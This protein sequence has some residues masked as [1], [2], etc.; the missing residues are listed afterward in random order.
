MHSGDPK[1]HSI[2]Q[3]TSEPTVVR[4]EKWLR[5]LGCESRQV[6]YLTERLAPTTREGVSTMYCSQC[7]VANNNTRYTKKQEM[8]SY[9]EKNQLVDSNHEKTQM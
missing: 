9:Q 5:S 7:V 4:L 1:V 3:P 2:N 8:W 6:E